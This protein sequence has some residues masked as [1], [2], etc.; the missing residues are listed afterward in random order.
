M[1]RILGNHHA[2]VILLLLLLLL[3]LLYLKKLSLQ[4]NS[5]QIYIGTEG[6]TKDLILQVQKDCIRIYEKFEDLGANIDR[7]LSTKLIKV[8]Q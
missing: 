6:E 2:T 1:S 4:V 8:E 3:L 5:E 7:L